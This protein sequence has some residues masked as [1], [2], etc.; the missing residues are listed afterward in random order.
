MMTL[1]NTT[2]LRPGLLV[3]LKTSVSGN[4][5]YS[6]QEIE[7]DHLTPD[8]KRQAR[9]ET[10]RVISDP[11][12][13]EAA[14]KARSRALTMIRT[15]CSRSAFG[16]LCPEIDTER[17][18][19]AIADARR[20]ADEFNATA[21]LTRVTVYVI[22]GRIA[23]DDVEAV[24][25]INSE[26]RDLLDD[27]E[28]GLKRLDVDAVREAANKARN[29]GAMLSPDAA[30]RVRS[31]IEVARQA[32]RRIVQAGDQ[33]AVDIDRAAL[34]RIEEARTAFLDLDEGKRIE[35]PIV[36]GRALDLMPARSVRKA[37]EPNRIMEV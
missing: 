22:T 30:A 19:R 34:R 26:I 29:I 23:P 6:K 32:A 37:N 18:E 21:R 13:H 36:E 24:R 33:A 3:S 31:A 8:G 9:W 7:Q 20:I 28:R 2:T 10:E 1:R 35:A 5:S 27:M 16:L 4:V 14:T 12:E 11:K 17:L 15:V 25:A